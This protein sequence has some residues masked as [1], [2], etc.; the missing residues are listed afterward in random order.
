MAGGGI[1]GPKATSSPQELEVG[2]RRAPYLLVEN[3]WSQLEWELDMAITSRDGRQGAA[4][5]RAAHA[6]AH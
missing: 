6:W 3:T 2:A 4:A 5:V 1:G